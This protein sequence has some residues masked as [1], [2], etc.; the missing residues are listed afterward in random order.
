MK[1]ATY[2][3]IVLVLL[4]SS[5]MAQSGFRP[6]YIIKHNGD[7]LNGLVLYGSNGKF[8]KSCQFRRFEIAQEVSYSPDQIDAYGFRNGR[9]FESKTTGRKK[10][11]LECLVKGDVSVYIIP[12]KYNGSVYLQSPRT[13]L[14]KLAK[15][16]NNLP[17]GGN[18][19]SY[20]DALAWMLNNTG[21]QQVSLANTEYAAKDIAAA[22]RESSSLSEHASKG[23][24]ATPGVQRLRDN[25]VMKQGSLL[26]I[27]LTGGYQFVNVTTPGNASTPLFRE[28]KFNKSYRPALG[29]YI[30]TNFSRKSNLLSAD[31]GLQFV[32]DSYYAYS[33]YSNGFEKSADD[34][35][36]DFSEIQVPL[37]IRLTFG[38]GSIHPYIRAGGFI[39]FILNQ[40]YSRLAYKERGESVYTDI[41]KDLT[42]DNAFGFGGGAGLEFELGM[43]RVL[44]LEC[45]YSKGSQNLSK[46]NS[47]QGTD[48]NTSVISIMARVNL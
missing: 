19:N 46:S 47:R 33:D 15:G 9:Y 26:S 3:S 16:N 23:Y 5:M 8:E 20:K 17:G 7:T 42:L 43:A 28:A 48:L 34:I 18:F 45:I 11:F 13:G 6:G 2:F 32:T 39:S 36:I 14:F 24:Y 35:N 22:V 37:S 25:S 38:K 21:N 12:G 4:G 1:K 27:G 44:G 29:M 30:K 40:S 10:A 31:L 41:Y